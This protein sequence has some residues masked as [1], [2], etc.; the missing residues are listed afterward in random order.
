MELFKAEYFTA[1]NVSSESRPLDDRKCDLQGGVC[2]FRHC[3]KRQHYVGGLCHN[4]NY[5]CC[6]G[7]GNCAS[8]GIEGDNII[9]KFNFKLTILIY[10]Y[11]SL[12]IPK[13]SILYI[14]FDKLN[15]IDVLFLMTNG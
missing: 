12:K 6:L 5:V 3:C 1:T 15:L 8:V 7:D 4:E 9:C 11:Y 13:I 14:A 10:S 2:T